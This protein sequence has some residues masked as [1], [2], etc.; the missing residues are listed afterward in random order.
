MGEFAYLDAPTPIAFAHRGGLV[1]GEENTMAA[2]AHAV[3][4]GY[5]YLETDVH[6]TADGVP[7]VFHDENLRRVL[8]HDDRV[9]ALTW[10]DLAT[11]REGGA[12]VLPSLAELLEQFPDRRFNIDVKADSAVAPTIAVV[13]RARARE[14]TLLAS[15]SSA[16]LRRIRAL[17]GPG[18]AT[19]MGQAEVA[20]LWLASRWGRGLVGALPR[21][22]AVQ[23]P[24]RFG[25][26]RV[27]D[28]RFIRYAHAAG[29]QV[30]VWTINDPAEMRDLLD[31][32]VDGIMT[33]HTEVLRE[34]LVARGQW[35]A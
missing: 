2:F 34:V 27:V 13:A 35:A 10:A 7:V 32:G 24:A 22:P 31:R 6:A 33:D 20:R 26:L 4:L 23:V 29:I 30:H 21:V 3:S 14:R 18:Q 15:F 11:V 25:V 19:S 5:R 9:D 28:G 16:R 12:S 17:C 8:G 1:D